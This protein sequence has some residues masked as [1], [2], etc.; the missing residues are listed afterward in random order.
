MKKIL[1]MFG[2]KSTEHEVSYLSAKSIYENINLK[3]WKVDICYLDR[4]NNFYTV[5]KIYDLANKETIENP[6]EYLKKYDCIFNII[7]GNYGEDGKIQGFLDFIGV[8]YV[9]AKTLS[10]AIGMDKDI[11]KTL[12]KGL[13]IPQVPYLVTTYLDCNFKDMESLGYPLIV[14]PANGGSSIGITK[15]NNRKDLMRAIKL[16]NKYDKKIIVEKFIYGRELEC[17]VIEEKDELYAS[18]IGEIKSANEFYDFDAKYKNNESE[19][20]IPAK[21]PATINEQIKE[22]AKKA[23]IAINA[24]GL[25]RVDFFYDEKNKQIYLNEI[26]TLP[27]FTTISMYPKMLIHDKYTYTGIIDK[28]I[29]NSLK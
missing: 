15:A 14:K 6:I 11:C 22:S 9:G 4:E 10:S 13:D 16:A 28:L 17:S 25:S 19:T 24:K 3:K 21:I 29:K 18:S 26:N 23:F 27:G 2:G 7:H 1:L 20:I 5:E 12:F 8:K